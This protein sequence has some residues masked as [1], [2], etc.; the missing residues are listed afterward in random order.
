MAYKIQ[1]GEANLGGSITVPGDIAVEA[2]SFTDSIATTNTSANIQAS[3]NARHKIKKGFTISGTG[4]PADTTVTS[5]DNANG[6]ITMSAAATNSATVTLT[7][8]G[9]Y[10]A[11]GS[12]V[13]SDAVI[14]I[15]G[16]A[17]SNLNAATNSSV[18]IGT[19]AVFHDAANLGAVAST[20]Q[21]IIM[22]KDSQGGGYIEMRTP[23]DT[24][25]IALG[26]AQDGSNKD[27]VLLLSS[28]VTSG[29]DIELNA[30]TGSGLIR[31]KDL[32]V[33]GNMVVEGNMTM[34]NTQLIVSGTTSQLA[35]SS[36][37]I[38]D[39]ILMMNSSS[40]AAAISEGGFIFGAD[41]TGSSAVDGG[42][43][44]TYGDTGTKW[45]AKEAVSVER[46]AAMSASFYYDAGSNQTNLTRNMQLG[47][48]VDITADATLSNSNVG[49]LH[50]CKDSSQIILTLPAAATTGNGNYYRIKNVGS[51]TIAVK[52][53]SGEQLDG[54]EYSSGNGLEIPNSKVALDI[55][56][57]GSHYFI[58]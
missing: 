10:D 20:N 6:N 52:T 53:Q 27:G 55:A 54:K 41:K 33:E 50:A 18:L 16:S 38:A 37:T 2:V 57:N 29:T 17:D 14:T 30:I 32:G 58:M 40:A 1:I 36:L 21:R 31:T 43:S 12:V 47:A 34:T 9:K 28:D 3:V 8:T 48:T 26:T 23:A 5:V 49:K 56:S 19:Q 46:F 25:K 44:L 7:F 24:A 35:V 51:S 11:K 13:A 15:T 39:D 45:M 22:K 42:A 4:I